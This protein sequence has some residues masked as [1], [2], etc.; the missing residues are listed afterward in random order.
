[1]SSAGFEVEMERVR[2]CREGEKG[3]G[4]GEEGSKGVCV[5]GGNAVGG[6]GWRGGAAEG[7]GLCLTRWHFE[8]DASRGVYVW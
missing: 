2:G 7:G 3:M 8:L 5:G 6:S 1:M 4:E